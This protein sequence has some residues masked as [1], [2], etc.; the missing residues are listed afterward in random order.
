[1]DY[2]HESLNSR[3]SPKSIWK[4]VAEGDQRNLNIEKED[5]L[6]RNKWK[7]L[8]MGTR[9]IVKIVMVNVPDD[10]LFWLT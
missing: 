6:V 9:R 5:I 3:G 8:I 4:E 1:M 2:V 10:F 7:R